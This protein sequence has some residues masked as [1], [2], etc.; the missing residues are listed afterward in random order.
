[1]EPVDGSWID[2]ADQIYPQAW[3]FLQSPR[4]QQ[5]C[6]SAAVY[7][8]LNNDVF[9]KPDGTP[10]VLADGTSPGW[11][12]VGGVPKYCLDIPNKRLRLPDLRG[13]YF[14][15]AGCDSLG[16][17]MV[18]GYALPAALCATFASGSGSNVGGIRGAST[19]G[20]FEATVS[21]PQMFSATTGTA[22]GDAY[23]RMIFDPDRVVP[24]AARNQVPAW[25]SLAC[26]YLGR[27][28][29]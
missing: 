2:N 5:L 24:T 19:T 3:A 25:G 13:T 7:Q 27:P 12:G 14:E 29:S 15:P 1:M 11:K 6:V 20:A 26:V 4:G 21:V 28:A 17:A 9:R 23:S 8:A 10:I 18:H 22:S 16:V